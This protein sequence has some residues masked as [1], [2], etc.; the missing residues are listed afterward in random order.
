MPQQ[1]GLDD[2]AIE[3][4]T[5]VELPERDAM[6]LVDGGIKLVPISP[7]VVPNPAQPLEDS[8][9]VDTIGQGIDGRAIE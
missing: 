6:S 3:Q 5:A 9:A 7:V 2:E 1:Q 8:A 4:E